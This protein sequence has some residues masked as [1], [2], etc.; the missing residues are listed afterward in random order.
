MLRTALQAYATTQTLSRLEDAVDELRRVFL[1][2]GRR[3]LRKSALLAA[4]RWL[5]PVSDAALADVCRMYERAY[6]GVERDSGVEDDIGPIAAWP[7][8]ERSQGDGEPTARME[9]AIPD[10]RNGHC[11]QKRPYRRPETPPR[12]ETPAP[13]HETRDLDKEILLS[14]C[15]PNLDDHS[16]LDAVETWYRRVHVGQIDPLRSH[17]ALVE[18]MPPSPSP[19]PPPP[20]PKS[21]P[22]APRQQR[23]VDNEIHVTLRVAST[24]PKLQPAPPG[25]AL[26]LKLQTTFDRAQTAKQQDPNTQAQGTAEEEEEDLTARPTS[27]IKTG[28]DPHIV[29]LSVSFPFPSAN[30]TPAQI[31]NQSQGKP[32][33]WSRTRISGGKGGSNGGTSIDGM[34][35]HGCGQQQGHEEAETEADERV[36]RVGPMTPNGYDDISPV[37]RGEWGF[38]MGEGLIGRVA[39]V[40]TC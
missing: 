6:G 33:H 11:Q 1:A 5:S 7:L 26:A 12:L 4:Y 13:D 40:E 15:E 37:T 39:R 8:A 17:P 14:A 20:P 30:P 21:P 31:H 24:S 3:P 34:L 28:P 23:P 2:N 19:T 25:R 32:S 22:Y 9:M 35:L 29:P 36:E 27:A 38:L 16:D 10:R 18:I